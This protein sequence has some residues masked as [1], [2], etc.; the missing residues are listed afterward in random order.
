MSNEQ[1]ID[2]QNKAYLFLAKKYAEEVA[3][4]AV[5]GIANTLT[6]QEIRLI[7]ADAKILELAKQN[8]QEK[9]SEYSRV[10][11]AE[12]NSVLDQDYPLGSFISV[13]ATCSQ[14]EGRLP[15]LENGPKVNSTL[16]NIYLN[17]LDTKSGQ[18]FHWFD[19]KEVFTNG[20]I[21]MPGVWRSRG[22]C[23]GFSNEV[24]G[25][26]YYLAQRVQ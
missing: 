8:T 15:Y 1:Y 7:Q 19:G 6:E 4:Q 22:I 24:V 25:F 16:N 9:L 23:G 13:S 2:S 17:I 20:F 3:N 18:V 10:C 11:R 21:K 14:E 26:K 12:E 5:G